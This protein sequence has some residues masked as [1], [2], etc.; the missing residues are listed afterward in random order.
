VAK[1]CHSI[2]WFPDY[3][4]YI[5]IKIIYLSWEF[6]I[7]IYIY[8]SWF[9]LQERI[10]LEQSGIKGLRCEMNSPFPAKHIND[11]IFIKDLTSR[12]QWLQYDV[13]L[14]IKIKDKMFVSGLLLDNIQLLHFIEC[15]M[16]CYG[17]LKSN[18]DQGRRPRSILLFS[19]P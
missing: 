19:A 18:I 9:A 16:M 11:S 15:D 13:I 14:H 6:S 8:Y 3:F 5:R 17:A 10:F 12:R 4:S 1:Y 2:N 7:Y